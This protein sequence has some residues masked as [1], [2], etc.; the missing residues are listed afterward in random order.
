[1]VATKRRTSMA[2]AFANLCK[3]NYK[4]QAIY[5]M[6]GFWGEVVKPD[7]A[8][9]FWN[10]VHKFVEIDK[11]GTNPAGEN[12]SELDQFWSA[13][14]LED[15]DSAM[16]AIERKNALKLIDQNN[17][18][19][20]AVIEYLIWK[21]K[22]TVDETVNSPQGGGTAEDAK[23]L[24]E[25]QKEL[26]K[27]QTLLGE[28]QV[29]QEE[30]KKQEDEYAKKVKELE[31][32]SQGTGIQAMKASNELAQLKAEDP[33]PLR[34]AK[35]TTDAA[36]RKVLKQLESTQQL[37][38]ELRKRGGVASGVLWWMQREMFEADS[39]LPTSKMK[40][41]HKKPFFYDPLGK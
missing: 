26:A 25:A 40:F 21:H 30:Q 38:D 12:G 16:T 3:L 28:L 2:Q 41:D 4:E 22:K 34:K 9:T 5:F 20:M 10:I 8:E 19:K 15:F 37:V 36:M 6:N 18:G 39:R 13:K 27:L 29:A 7:N 11:K 14:F 23:A 32:K 33:L 17:N 1:V 24:A 35:I 31:A